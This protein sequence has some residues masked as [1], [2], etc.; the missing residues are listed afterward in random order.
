M[1]CFAAT[2]VPLQCKSYKTL[3]EPNRAMAQLLGKASPLCD[4]TITTGW[5]RFIGPAGNNMPTSCVDK[6]RCGTHASGWI[7]GALPTVKYQQVER[8]VCFHWGNNCCMWNKMIN[9]TNCNGFNVYYL[10]KPP[11]CSLRYCGDRGGIVSYGLD[12]CCQMVGV[13]VMSNPSI[14]PKK[15]YS[16]SSSCLASYPV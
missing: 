4:N 8:K 16:V 3:S 15:P 11:A 6:N 13:F 12:S 7:T 14:D 2:P 9:V 10:H 1:I 5:Y